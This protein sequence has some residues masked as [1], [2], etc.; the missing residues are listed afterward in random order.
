VTV[1]LPASPS[2]PPPPQ[3]ASDALSARESALASQQASLQAELDALLSKQEERLRAWEAHCGDIEQE[4]ET[5]RAQLA[6]EE[7]RCVGRGLCVCVGGGAC[8]TGVE[9][10]CW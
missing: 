9:L 6:A 8:W 4:L 3:A 5:R 10:C 2:P 1:C 7:Q